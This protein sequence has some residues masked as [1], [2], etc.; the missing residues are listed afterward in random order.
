M[1]ESTG[2]PTEWTLRWDCFCPLLFETMTSHMNANNRIKSVFVF[3]RWHYTYSTGFA[4]Y[5]GTQFTFFFR[6]KQKLNCGTRQLSLI[7]IFYGS[8]CCVS[9]SNLSWIG[10]EMKRHHLSNQFYLMFIHCFISKQWLRSATIY[11]NGVGYIDVLIL[12]MQ[13][14]VVGSM[15]GKENS[16]LA[17]ICMHCAIRKYNGWFNKVMWIKCRA[18]TKA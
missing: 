15:M 7:L 16:Q 4:W 5:S 17:I 1:I 10:Q 12:R 13:A 11:I 18:S 9:Y 6:D 8:V 2:Q 14:V 3:I